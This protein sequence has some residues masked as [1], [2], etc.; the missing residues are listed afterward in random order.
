MQNTITINKLNSEVN[1]LKTE[2]DEIKEAIN[3]LTQTK[4]PQIMG[5]HKS[6]KKI[7]K[8]EDDKIWESYL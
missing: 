7:W 4:Y 2:L 5:S 6:L 8:N 3:V 1:S